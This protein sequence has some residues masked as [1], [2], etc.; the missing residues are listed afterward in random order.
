MLGDVVMNVVV[1]C[2]ASIATLQKLKALVRDHYDFYIGSEAYEKNK[3][4][5]THAYREFESLDTLIRDLIK[6]VEV[7]S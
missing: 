6:Q 3:K 4:F 5:N 7:N 2:N 1:K